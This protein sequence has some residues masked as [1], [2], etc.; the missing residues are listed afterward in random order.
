MRPEHYTILGVPH[1]GNFIVTLET[2][3]LAD[4]STLLGPAKEYRPS[5]AEYEQT[6]RCYVSARPGD[7]TAI[8]F[9]NGINDLAS[10]VT[11]LADKRRVRHLSQCAPSPSVEA[12]L[13]TASG[14]RVGLS[15]V[16]VE[17]ILG[18]PHGLRKEKLLY[19]AEAKLPITSSV[20]QRLGWLDPQDTTT[21]MQIFRGVTI[22]LDKDGAVSAF[23]VQQ[24]SG[25]LE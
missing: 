15:R 8:L 1:S 5:I 16:Q 10:E 3:R 13:A 14:L 21:T 6:M 18:P 2:V 9:R 7:A 23:Q 20:R 19:A 4:L 22:W 11:V 17:S 25:Q 24:V 12:G